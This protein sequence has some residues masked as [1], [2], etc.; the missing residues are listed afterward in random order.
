MILPIKKLSIRTKHIWTIRLSSTCAFQTVRN[1]LIANVVNFWLIESLGAA[2]FTREIKLQ[3]IIIL[4]FLAGS[5]II[6]SN[7]I[8]NAFSKIL[9]ILIYIRSWLILLSKS[10][11]QGIY[12][13]L[14]L[15]FFWNFHCIRDNLTRLSK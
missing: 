9:T 13:K 5:Y 7:T 10:I 15:I 8:F 14:A 1:A 11:F 12:H 2:L 3:I 4:T 6:T